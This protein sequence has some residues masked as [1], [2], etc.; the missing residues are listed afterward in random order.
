MEE[1]NLLKM[2][3][4]L[5]HCHSIIKM[6]CRITIYIEIIESYLLRSEMRTIAKRRAVKD[7]VIG[8]EVLISLI[9]TFV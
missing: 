9:Y 2:I 3:K 7:G 5:Y 6:S 4:V 1:D 8:Q